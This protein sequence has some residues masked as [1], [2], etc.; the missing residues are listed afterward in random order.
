MSAGALSTI[1]RTSPYWAEFITDPY[2]G[3]FP[4]A[5]VSHTQIYCVIMVQTSPFVSLVDGCLFFALSMSGIFN[6]C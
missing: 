3:I 2:F 4:K 5:R 6:G 1:L